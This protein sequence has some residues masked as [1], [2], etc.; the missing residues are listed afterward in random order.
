MTEV[1]ETFLAI[2]THL[3]SKEF[4]EARVNA[5]KDAFPVPDDG[6]ERNFLLG[7]LKELKNLASKLLECKEE[8]GKIEDFENCTLSARTAAYEFLHFPHTASNARFYM[9]YSLKSRLDDIFKDL[10]I[11]VLGK[12][13]CF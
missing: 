4:Y 10:G 11:T 3:S 1:Y 7:H 6:Y 5:I 13:G 2:L 9:I 8:L 12:C